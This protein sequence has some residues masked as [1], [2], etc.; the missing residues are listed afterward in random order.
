MRLKPLDDEIEYIKFIVDTKQRS[1]IQNKINRLHINMCLS[2]S[3]SEFIESLYFIYIFGLAI[4]ILY[5]KLD[6]L[7]L[8]LECKK[9]LYDCYKKSNYYTDLLVQYM[10]NEQKNIGFTNIQLVYIKNT[11][12]KFKTNFNEIF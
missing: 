1:F 7:G 3:D 5:S 9:F 11:I 4:L 2:T 10:R 6:V 12:D 8:S